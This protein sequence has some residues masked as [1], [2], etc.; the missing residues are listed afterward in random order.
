MIFLCLKI[1]QESVNLTGISEAIKNKDSI[2]LKNLQAKNT[3]SL[4]S[5]CRE[6]EP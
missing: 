2:I 5:T 1:L 4:S 3:F 6:K